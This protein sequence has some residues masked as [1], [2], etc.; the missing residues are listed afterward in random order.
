MSFGLVVEPEVRAEMAAAAIWY[1][2]RERGLGSRFLDAADAALKSV[3]QAPRQYQ[4]VRKRGEVRRVTVHDF[5]YGLFYL[6]SE[7]DVIVVACVHGR[8][9]PRRWQTRVP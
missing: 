6:V 8:R 3:Q 4:I 7:S 1:E 2:G 5:P 9:H